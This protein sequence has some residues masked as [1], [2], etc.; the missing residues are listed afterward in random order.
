MLDPR[1]LAQIA[2]DFG[3]SDPAG[4]P[5]PFDQSRTCAL[6]DL[7][8]PV[9]LFGGTALARTHLSDP[10]AGARLS[11]DIDLYTPQRRAT[12]VVLDERLPQRLRREFPGIRWDPTLAKVGS[13]EPGQWSPAMGRE[14]GFS[15][16]IPMSSIKTTG[17]P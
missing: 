1:E 5:R 14:S 9:I 15:C 4:S 6:A 10:D 7:A 8:L 3:V 13:V 16:W 2:A 11:E 12:A 17:R